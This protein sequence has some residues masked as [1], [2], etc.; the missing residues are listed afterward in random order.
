MFFQENYVRAAVMKVGGP[1]E[2]SNQLNV[3]NGCVH[4]WVKAGRI[5]KIN[6]ARKLADLS[7]ISVE[8][9]RGGV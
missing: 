4:K 1:T 2:T 5:S 7:G 9:L 6:Q 8:K 3:S